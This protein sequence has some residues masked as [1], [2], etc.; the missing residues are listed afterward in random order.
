MKLRH[1][2]LKNTGILFE[3][4][5][6]QITSDTVSNKDSHA[7][8]I[9]K[10]YFSK[11]ELN[12]EYKLY[13]SLI[14]QTSLNESKAQSFIDIVM[15]SYK[16]INRSLLKK[17]K[18]N[19][20]KEIKEHYNINE[21]FKYKIPYYKEYAAIYNLIESKYSNNISDPEILLQNKSTLLEHITYNNNKKEEINEEFEELKKADPSYRSLVYKLM[22][23]EFNNRYKNFS[24]FQK[25]ILKE[26][27]IYSNNKEKLLEMINNKYNIIRTNL[28]KES[29]K[30]KDDITKI[31]LKEVISLITPKQK[32]NEED[33]SLLLQYSDLYN[34]IKNI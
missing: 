24:P 32:F 15:D 28:I 27:I 3:L 33:I 13:K 12:K 7:I 14:S 26:Y 17:E 23:E 5:V 4:L 11:G 2:K 16:K 1:S 29:K 19:L 10:K 21:F 18:Y 8:D 6:R 34:E 31:K 22:L 30:I 9:V 25:T 20:I